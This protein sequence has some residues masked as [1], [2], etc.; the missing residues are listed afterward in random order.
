MSINNR[1]KA[2]RKSKKM[3][4]QSLSDKTGLSRIMLSKVE[5]GETQ[6][7]LKHIEALCVFFDVTADYLI[8]GQDVTL[9]NNER[10]IIKAVR[11]DKSLLSS[12][13]R[14][15]ESKNEFESLVA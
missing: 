8:N 12:L 3:T 11:K 9:N 10:E 2:L 5:T 7:T 4:Q 14:M 15:I 6:P 13:T 1:I